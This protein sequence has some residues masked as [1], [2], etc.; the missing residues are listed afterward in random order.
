MKYLPVDFKSS[1]HDVEQGL[2]GGGF[3]LAFIL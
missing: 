3:F 2:G 1:Q